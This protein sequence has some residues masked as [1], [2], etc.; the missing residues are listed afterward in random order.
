MPSF[1]HKYAHVCVHVQGTENHCLACN[2]GELLI[3]FL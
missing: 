1:K 2:A 3:T